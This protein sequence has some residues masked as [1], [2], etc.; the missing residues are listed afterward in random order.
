[1]SDTL[2]LPEVEIRSDFIIDN[3]GFKRTR[4]DSGIFMQNLTAD[5]ADIL[6]DHSTIFI[7]SYGNGTLSTPSFRGT[8]AQH[9]Q[10]E[11]NGISLNSPMLGQM[12]FSQVPVAQFD[13]LEILFGAAGISRTS[14]AFGGVIDL[15]TRPDWHNRFSAMAAQSIASF[16]NYTTNL[17][18]A[19]GGRS[20]QS[21]TRLNCNS[22][23]NDFPYTDDFGNVVRQKNASFT[24][25]GISQELFW[26]IKD[27]HLLSG[28]VWYSV[29][30]RNLPPT[31]QNY[32]SLKSETMN[33]RALRAL[34]E[35][36]LV[37][38]KWNLLVRSALNDQYMDYANSLLEIRSVHESWSWINRVRFSYGGV[39]NLTIR[40]GIDFT[41]DR[42]ESDDYQGI[43]T[44]STTG[45]FAEIN[46]NFSG[47]VKSSLVLREDVIDGKFQPLIPALGVEYRPFSKINLALTTNL[48]RN[49]RYP[50]LND[51]YW[52]GSGNPDLKPEKNYSIEAG[53]TFNCE[54]KSSNLFVEASLAGYYSWIH[55]MIVWMPVEGSGGLFR[56]QNITE[57]LA[58]GI[59]A[60]LNISLIAWK[61]RIGLKSNYSFCRSTY[62]E[63]GSQ[64]IYI[65]VNTFNSTF[66][67]ERWR[68][69]LNCICNFTG[70]RYTGS[71]NLSL[72][73]AYNIVNI[74]FGKNI[75]IRKFTLSLQVDINN[76]FNLDYQSL[77]NRPMP[78]INYAFTMKVS[79][80][81]AGDQ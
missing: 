70:E 74:L 68:F 32:D 43:K 28:K 14:G 48:A 23:I 41:Y 11:W 1:M 15:V 19:A 69:Y 37:D 79:F 58:R 8:S 16:G 47:K 53:G 24:D 65:P 60:G 26:K 81:K 35:Y 55:N 12:D 18:I 50:T 3:L 25:Y 22:A 62:E 67:V 31:T 29:A 59:E 56:P 66:S 54:T 46:Y 13:Y 10:V 52:E 71:D 49:Y 9:T 72:M 30:D 36:K 39:K 75:Q 2:R 44:R 63:T 57:I 21:H 34:I 61:F 42:V 45:F 64:Q 40:P 5:L 6:S 20:F 51:L 7:K 17:N 27:R 73:P 33:D 76:V 38:S 77:A 4:I 78:G 80:L